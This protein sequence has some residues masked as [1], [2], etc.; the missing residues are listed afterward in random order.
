MGCSKKNINDSF[1]K[2]ILERNNDKEIIIKLR[3]I[4]FENE[5]EV[6]DTR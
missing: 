5:I 4:F 6:Q 2:Y 1:H 3:N